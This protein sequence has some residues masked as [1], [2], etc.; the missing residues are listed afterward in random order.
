MRSI[1][2]NKK[3][4]KAII[5]CGKCSWEVSHVFN[6][7]LT[8]LIDCYFKNAGFYLTTTRMFINIIWPEDLKRWE[9]I[10]DTQTKFRQLTRFEDIFSEI[11]LTR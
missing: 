7:E 11:V 10:G 3:S 9:R 2:N 1:A 4:R 5:D 8:F 6:G